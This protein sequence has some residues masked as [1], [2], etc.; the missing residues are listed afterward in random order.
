MADDADRAAK[1]AAGKARLNKYK[2]KKKKPGSSAPAD[3]VSAPANALTDGSA[4]GVPEILPPT[5]GQAISE[6]EP[7]VPM[8]VHDTV[9]ASEPEPVEQK[10]YPTPADYFNA[11]PQ[12]QSDGSANPFSTIQQNLPAAAPSTEQST[13]S[14]FDQPPSPS[15][16]APVEVLPQTT[17]EQQAPAPI[18]PMAVAPPM[19]TA[20]PMIDSTAGYEEAE[21]LRM[22]NQQLRDDIESKASKMT[23]LL[24]SL[25]AEKDALEEQLRR[26]QGYRQENDMK[27][28]EMLETLEETR[29]EHMQIKS[30]LDKRESEVSLL[31]AQLQSVEQSTAANRGNQS[32]ELSQLREAKEEA[33]YQVSRMAAEIQRLQGLKQELFDTTEAKNAIENEIA[34]LRLRIDAAAIAE[35]SV[36]ELKQQNE[37]LIGQITTQDQTSDEQ[38]RLIVQQLSEEKDQAQHQIAAL[39]SQYEAIQQ[40]LAAEKEESERLR[41]VLEQHN[42]RGT[43]Q[44]AYDNAM[45]SKDQTI[46]D[47]TKELAE[48]KS[49]LVALSMELDGYQASSPV[50]QTGDEREIQELRMK[51]E[52]LTHEND[53]LVLEVEHKKRQVDALQQKSG[54]GASDRDME[55]QHYEKLLEDERT[56]VRELNTS[57][58]EI[59]SHTMYG[60]NQHDDDHARQNEQVYLEQIEDL[61]RQNAELRSSLGQLE[62]SHNDLRTQLNLAQAANNTTEDVTALKDELGLKRHRL[63]QLEEEVRQHDHLVATMGRE[64]QSQME[65]LEEHFNAEI[66][67]IKAQRTDE[68]AAEVEKLQKNIREQ[69]ESLILKNK[70]IAKMESIISEQNTRLQHI[71][72]KL[73]QAVHQHALTGTEKDQRISVL[74]QEIHNLQELNDNLRGQVTEQIEQNRV[75]LAGSDSLKLEVRSLQEKGTVAQTKQS[76][77]GQENNTLRDRV[78]ELESQLRGDHAQSEQLISTLQQEKQQLKSRAKGLQEDLSASMADKDA[79]VESLRNQIRGLQDR[80]TLVPQLEQEVVELRQAVAIAQRQALDANEQVSTTSVIA[81]N[82]HNRLEQDVQT[83]RAQIQNLEANYKDSTAEVKVR[84]GVIYG[85]EGTVAILREERDQEKDAAGKLRHEVDSLRRINNAL[86]AAGDPHQQ[87]SKQEQ[88][89]MVDAGVQRNGTPEFGNRQHILALEEELGQSRLETESMRDRIA[90]VQADAE[91]YRSQA[92]E[93]RERIEEL[94]R[95]LA[96]SAVLQHSSERERQ[97]G[98]KFVAL[99]SENQE[100]SQQ[101]VQLSKENDALRQSNSSAAAP[102]APAIP[103]TAEAVLVEVDYDDGKGLHR[104]TVQEAANQLRNLHLEHTMA[105]NRLRILKEEQEALREH[106]MH[107]ALEHSGDSELLNESGVDRSSTTDTMHQDP[108]SLFLHLKRSYEEN[109]EIIISSGRIAMRMYSQLLSALSHGSNVTVPPHLELTDSDG[110]FELMRKSQGLIEPFLSVLRQH[111]S[112]SGMVSSFSVT[113]KSSGGADSLRDPTIGRLSALLRDQEFA[114][115]QIRQKLATV[116]QKYDDLLLQNA[117]FSGSSPA[118]LKPPKQPQTPTQAQTAASLSRNSATADVT[119][120]TLQQQP[121]NAGAS[122]FPSNGSTPIATRFAEAGGM[123]SS[124]TMAMAAVRAYDANRP[125]YSS[126]ATSAYGHAAGADDTNDTLGAGTSPDMKSMPR[127]GDVPLHATVYLRDGRAGSVRYVGR[128]DFAPGLWFGLE[129]FS[130]DGRNDGEVQG[131]RYFHCRPGYGLFVKRSSINSVYPSTS[132]TVKY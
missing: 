52:Q 95:Q 32:E 45:A 76:E 38:H 56:K 36:R 104:F 114:V 57:L 14:L 9:S 117:R 115:Q 53:T 108:H 78:G 47:L 11:A 121:S 81:D 92:T 112:S 93:F 128:T 130:R 64:A 111:K 3:A 97:L 84:E 15:T 66:A 124:A 23:A 132:P 110:L 27:L 131:R 102:P 88:E 120:G 85:L 25:D 6:E 75:L 33:E 29:R 119:A 96:S 98:E 116:Q 37:R 83:L 100:M 69:E 125:H 17:I 43:G 62:L 16:T 74:E 72:E 44:P 35:K 65:E 8:A 71:D 10:S 103:P 89:H 39:A 68:T 58:E 105:H 1:L 107:S 113:S 20:P 91:K 73:A 63:E 31:K 59:R 4:A 77:L 7:H 67:K 122:N 2:K 34:Q 80:E 109:K 24:D 40:S 41:S 42:S 106:M 21:L 50:P 60:D 13:A 12:Q 19:A 86:K 79:Q 30:V 48:S 51:C 49:Q 87:H 22:E 101:L 129:L 90:G 61:R 126:R 54:T 94:E 127:L 123:T 70:A 46:A 82:E 55:M 28:R 99:E 5:N 18:P 26:E 118:G